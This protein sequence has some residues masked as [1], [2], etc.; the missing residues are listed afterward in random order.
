MATQEVTRN[1]WQSFLDRFSKQHQGEQATVQVI[2]EEVGAQTAV[3]SL[4]FV[5]ISAEEAG[6]AKGSIVILMGDTAGDHVE[7]RVADPDHLWQRLTG[8]DGK[9][10]LEIEGADGAKT[11]LQLVPEAL[12]T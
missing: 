12:L 6:S 8:D 11:I 2:G 9:D 3:Q 10:A 1:E 4:P 5:G 7:H